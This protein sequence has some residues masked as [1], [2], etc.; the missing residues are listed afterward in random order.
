MDR[1]SEPGKWGKWIF[2][3]ILT[4]LLAISLFTGEALRGSFGYV[5]PKGVLIVDGWQNIQYH[6]LLV[7]GH[8]PV[9]YT[10]LDVYKRQLYGQAP[11]KGRV[12]GPG[13]PAES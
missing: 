2:I 4:A 11:G 3:G 6:C 5:T 9:A 1:M 13:G 7:Q 10:H 8:S 12:S